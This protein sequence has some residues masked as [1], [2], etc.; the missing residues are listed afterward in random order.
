MAKNE[1]AGSEEMLEQYF[2]EISRIPLLT[3]EEEIALSKKVQT[4]DKRAQETL[5]KANLRLVVRI[6]KAFLTSGIS[7]MDLIQEGNIGLMTAAG[8]FDWNHGVRFSTYSAWWIRQGILRAISNKKR[9]IRIP[10]RKEE[11]LTRVERYCSDYASQYGCEPS[12]KEIAEKM[13][14]NPRQVVTIL[15][16]IQPVQSLDK[17]ATDDGATI[18]DTIE[19]MSFEPAKLWEREDTMENARKLLNILAEKEK[20]ILMYRFSFY[21]GKKFTLKNISEKLGISAETVRQIEIKALNKLRVQSEVWE[22][23]AV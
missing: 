17:E 12:V 14:I 15:S 13:D 3:P 10:H 6:C 23:A 7:F 2:E 1:K 8:K 18:L 21:E 16:V 5:V 19:D 20:Q 9:M 22:L 4:G 11:I